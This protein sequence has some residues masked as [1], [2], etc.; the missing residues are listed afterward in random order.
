MSTLTWLDRQRLS[1]LTEMSECRGPGSKNEIEAA[2][3]RTFAEANAGIIRL[4]EADGLPDGTTAVVAL[5]MGE[6]DAQS[7]LG[8][9]KA[10]QESYPLTVK[11]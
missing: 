10:S 2:L 4:A 11:D 7:V 5:G 6:H 9:A 1:G 8:M 3:K